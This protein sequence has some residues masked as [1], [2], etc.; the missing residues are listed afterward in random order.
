VADVA[1]ASYIRCVERLK[2]N[3]EGSSFFWDEMVFI[4]TDQVNGS[5]GEKVR[6]HSRFLRVILVQGPSYLLWTCRLETKKKRE[7]NPW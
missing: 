4:I 1:L 6:Y 3:T 2:T 7:K 5:K